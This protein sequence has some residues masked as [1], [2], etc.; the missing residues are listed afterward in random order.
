MKKFEITF[1]NSPRCRLIF[2]AGDL[3]KASTYSASVAEGYGFYDDKEQ[4]V[5]VVPRETLLTIRQ[6]SDDPS[7]SISAS[8]NEITF[9]NSPRCR[10]I[11]EA[12]ASIYSALAIEGYGF[13]DDKKQLVA[14]VPRENQFTI[15]QLR[16]DPSKTYGMNPS[17]GNR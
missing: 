10:L 14:V 13:Y 8:R 5:A 2:E 15:R 16:E 11:I 17:I 1:R 6:I 12:E 4:L 9:K 3:S 7:K